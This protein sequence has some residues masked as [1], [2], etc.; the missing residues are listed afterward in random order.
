MCLLIHWACGDVKPRSDSFVTHWLL[1]IHCKRVPSALAQLH[2]K[3]QRP[4]D[5]GWNT[6]CLCVSCVCSVAAHCVSATRVRASLYEPA[7]SQPLASR[8][9][10]TMSAA[11]AH[12]RLGSQRFASSS[13]SRS[14]TCRQHRSC[15]PVPSG[16]SASYARQH[17]RRPSV[18]A[19]AT[20]QED[21]GDRVIAS[22]PYLLPLLDAIPFGERP[23]ELSGGR[24]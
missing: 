20:N 9:Q 17:L 4:S 13:V 23:S 18:H 7:L 16:P 2:K 11:M 19:R 12:T 10:P 22:L 15:L 6:F 1:L 24:R 8:T 14:T 3:P 5:V 21:I